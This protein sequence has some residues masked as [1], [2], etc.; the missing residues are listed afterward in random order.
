MIAESK[1]PDRS[2]YIGAKTEGFGIT[3]VQDGLLIKLTNNGELVWIK[4]IGGLGS[5]LLSRI[6]TEE[7]GSVIVM[8]NTDS[9]GEGSYD[10]L[11]L[12][13]N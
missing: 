1:D 7:D 8:G 12:K 9:Y 5:T 6:A 2:I 10:I 13:L 11:I 4:R 3:N